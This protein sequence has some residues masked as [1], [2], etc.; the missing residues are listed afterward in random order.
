MPLTKTQYASRALREARRGLTEAE[1]RLDL[2]QATLFLP[3]A[4]HAF[5]EGVSRD[6]YKR[7]KMR[8]RFEIHLSASGVATLADYP[9][10]LTSG[11]PFA[12]VYDAQDVEYRNQFQYKQQASQLNRPLDPNFGY[13]AV[14]DRESLVARAGAGFGNTFDLVVFGPYIPDFTDNY[15]VP[16]EFEEEAIRMLAELLRPG[17]MAASK[18]AAPN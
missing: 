8:G 15:P 7:G 2:A 1:S 17:L 4:I 3:E 14:R 10:L 16:P 18:N 5:A 13:Y 12:E 6:P 11:L 9:Q